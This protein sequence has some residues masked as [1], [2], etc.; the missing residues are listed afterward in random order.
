MDDR[1]SFSKLANDLD[2]LFQE[3]ETK[4][5]AAYYYFVQDKTD[6]RLAWDVDPGTIDSNFT[7]LEPRK[8]LPAQKW[9]D[10]DVKMFHESFGNLPQDD[11]V[12]SIFHKAF[13]LVEPFLCARS[14]NTASWP[15][16]MMGWYIQSDEEDNE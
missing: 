5:I 4:A 10:F 3:I 8:P 12:K 15:N 9:P 14:S 11:A 13:D 1:N 6:K 2:E 16:I 7:V